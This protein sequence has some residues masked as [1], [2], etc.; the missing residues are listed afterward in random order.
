M[1]SAMMLYPVSTSFTFVFHAFIIL[2]RFRLECRWQN[3][4]VLQP[5]A[6]C[7]PVCTCAHKISKGY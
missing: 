5:F 3:P 4:P 1:S 6:S 2:A 7:S